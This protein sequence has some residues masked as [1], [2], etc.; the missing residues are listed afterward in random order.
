MA[1]PDIL[2]NTAGYTILR[3]LITAEQPVK[4]QDL[5]RLFKDSG[6]TKG[7]FRTRRMLPLIKHNLVK[8]ATPSPPT[9]AESIHP[10][11]IQ[12]AYEMNWSGTWSYFVQH[13]LPKL[14]GAY[15]KISDLIDPPEENS[16]EIIYLKERF[17]EYAH[18]S[19]NHKSQNSGRHIRLKIN[20]IHDLF[21]FVQGDILLFGLA[22]ISMPDLEET[23]NN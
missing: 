13:Y 23:E 21:E 11:R 12:K 20:T 5:L 7:T 10:T 14:S 3:T 18:K 8:E 19:E 22:S 16:F 4:N 1:K 2:H 15:Q 6:L 17:R 9:T